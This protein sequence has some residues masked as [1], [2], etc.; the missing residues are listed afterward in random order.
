MSAESTRHAFGPGSGVYEVT[1][2]L[3][4]AL[5]AAQA[6]AEA[7]VA[8]LGAQKGQVLRELNELGFTHR[9]LGPMFGISY[10]R[11]KQLIDKA[12]EAWP[13][14]RGFADQPIGIDRP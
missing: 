7:H 3:W 2:N 11:V 12:K 6:A 14:R 10:P 5:C 8:V 9:E 13:D 4:D 1:R